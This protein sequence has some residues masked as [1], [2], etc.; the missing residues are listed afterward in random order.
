MLD[1]FEIKERNFTPREI[2]SELDRYIVGQKD[3]KRAVALALRNR[4]RRLQVEDDMKDEITP[5]N[6]VLIGSTGVGKTEIARRLAKL[7]KAPFFKVEATK[8]TEVGY[9]G[10]DVESIIRDLMEVSVKMVAEE[11]RQYVEHRAEAEAENKLVKMI[12]NQSSYEEFSQFPS[13]KEL[14]IKQQLREGL[15]DDRYISIKIDSN[16]GSNFQFV[17]PQ[18]MEDMDMNFREMLG[19]LMPGKSSDKKMKVSEAKKVLLEQEKESMLDRDM[20]S[21][22]AVERVEESGIVFIDEIDKIV[23]SKNRAGGDISREGVQRDL[24]PIVEGSTVKTKY[25]MIKTDHI[26]FVAAGAF[27]NCKPSDLL[28]ELQG[29]FPIRVE[30]SSLKKDDF[31]RILKEPKNSLP[32]QY[33]SLLKTEGISLSF[34]DEAIDEIAKTAV[35]ANKQMED[36]GARRLHTLMEKLLEEISFQSADMPSQEISVDI[37]MVKKQIGSLIEDKDLSHYIL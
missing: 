37:E 18:G 15:L 22:Y 33:T 28:P 6:I 2:I 1:Q 16:P 25:G 19:N 7:V 21:K 35:E 31:V 12:A 32:K 34:T 11:M 3:A 5:K 27:S 10:R 29:R 20:V 30:L 36:I 8:F 17:M 26:L 4:W 23:G 14:K 24:L 13:E 9:V